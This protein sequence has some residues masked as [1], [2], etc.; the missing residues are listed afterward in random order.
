MSLLIFLFALVL[1][2][3]AAIPV[4]ACQIEV[5]K[6]A[7][8]GHV[9]AS[10]TVVAGS[11]VADS[12]FGTVAL[13][14]I[15]PALEIPGVLAVFSAAAALILWFLAYRTWLESTRP[16]E[17]DLQ[18]SLSSR[19]WALATGFLLGISNPTLVLSWLFG[20]AI[21]KRVGLV[22]VLTYT[23][24]V[25]FVAGG[26]LGLGGYLVATSLVTLRMRHFL[27]VRALGR[28]YWWLAL[29]LFVLSFYFVHG[30][31]AYFTRAS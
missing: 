25:S 7:M 20:V 14:G 17:L 4:G 8:A 2:L 5:V 18:R 30:V 24:K 31:Y 12:I 1:G 28:I 9:F 19:R 13:F 27:S 21:A 16:H 3:L 10:L 22:P 29:T 26:V 23:A 11:A 15:A 6:R